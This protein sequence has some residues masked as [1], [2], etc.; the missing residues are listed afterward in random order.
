MREFGALQSVFSSHSGELASARMVK[1]ARPDDGRLALWA[2]GAVKFVGHMRLRSAVFECA[3]PRSVPMTA[4][5]L[6][7]PNGL[8][9][10]FSR[11]L[12]PSSPQ[13]MPKH[14]SR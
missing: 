5:I 12:Q 7:I 3:V 14:I 6:R 13:Y 1:R 4:C 2:I 8:T 11:L 10:L 9:A